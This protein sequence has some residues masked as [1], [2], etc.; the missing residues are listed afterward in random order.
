MLRA[1]YHAR[2]GPDGLQ[3][4]DVRQLIALAAQQGLQPHWVAL[5]DIAELDENYWY[6]PGAGDAHL[7]TPR[8][9]AEHMRLVQAADTAYPILLCAQ[10]RLMDGMHRVL[11]R[12]LQGESHVWALRFAQTPPPDH[13]GQP[14]DALPYDDDV[15]A[16]DQ[17]RA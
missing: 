16:A 4:W 10:G 15:D 1:Q 5:A 13:V 17:P 11:Q 8:A 14:L 6:A 12:L 7:P 9:L 2:P 3:A